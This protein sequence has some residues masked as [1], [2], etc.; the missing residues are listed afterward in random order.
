MISLEDCRF[1]AWADTTG[2]ISDYGIWT[3]LGIAA[4]LEPRGRDRTLTEKVPRSRSLLD[5]YASLSGNAR[6]RA[7]DDT[8]ATARQG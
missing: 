4:S 8:S 5:H 3:L 1:A 6:P 2:W 7:A